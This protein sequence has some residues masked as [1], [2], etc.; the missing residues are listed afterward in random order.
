MEFTPIH[1][2]TVIKYRMCFCVCVC[3]GGGWGGGVGEG[4]GLVSKITS[5][6]GFVGMRLYA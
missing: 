1:T 6:F 4:L 5:I 2:I 3:G